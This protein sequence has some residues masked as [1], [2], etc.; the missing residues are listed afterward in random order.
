[1]AHRGWAITADGHYGPQSDSVC[2]SF[3]AEKGLGVDGLVGPSTWKASWTA[4]LT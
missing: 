4:P 3:Q 2:R 1:M